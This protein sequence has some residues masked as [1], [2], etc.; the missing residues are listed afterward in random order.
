MQAMQ[1]DDIL[2]KSKF[3]MQEEKDNFSQISSN[4]SLNNNKNWICKKCNHRLNKPID[5]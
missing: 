4:N 1:E 3:K 5:R 2:E